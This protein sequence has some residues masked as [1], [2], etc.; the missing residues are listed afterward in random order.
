M[1][2]EGWGLEKWEL[3]GDRGLSHCQELDSN[4]NRVP[5]PWSPW[6][7]ATRNSP[8]KGAGITL[9]L[10]NTDRMQL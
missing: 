2:H 5:L 7:E 1:A 9:T 4:S 3:V 10:F 8:T 6:E